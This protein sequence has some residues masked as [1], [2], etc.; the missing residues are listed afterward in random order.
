METESNNEVKKDN[1]VVLKDEKTKV[2]DEEVC[3][4][5]HCR[6]RRERLKLMEELKKKEEEQLAKECEMEN[7]KSEEQDG[8]GD[9]CGHKNKSYNAPSCCHTHKSASKEYE[10]RD[11]IKKLT[12]IL[13]SL[14]SIVLSYIDIWKLVGLPNLRFLDFGYVAVVLCGYEIFVTAIMG[15]KKKKITSS[16]LVSIAMIASIVLEYAVGHTGGHSHSYIFAAGE[17]A[18]FMALGGLIEDWTV[19]KSRKGIER[20]IAMTPKTAMVKVG[21]NYE[22]TPISKLMIGDVVLVKPNEQVPVD[23]EIVKGES[24]I[25]QSSV[26]G[27]FVPVDVKPGDKV[28]GATY[29][30]QGVIEVKVTVPPKDMTVN[31]LIELVKEAEGQKAPISR[32]ADRWASY[33]VPSAVVLSLLIGVVSYFAFHLT[34]AQ[35]LIRA[36]TILVVFC[37]CSLT[38]ATPTAV[39]AG[40]GSAAY[41][42]VII[43]S[44]DAIERLAKVDTVAFDKTGTIT[45]GELNVEKVIAFDKTKE[46]DLLTMLGSIEKYSE[47]PIGKAIYKYAT[48]KVKKVPDP[49]NTRSLVGV[50]ISAKVDGKLVK[51]VSYK[52]AKKLYPED[53]N[54]DMLSEYLD[55]GYSI[56]VVISNFK[57][58][59]AVCLFDTLRDDAKDIIDLLKSK[60]YSTIMLT[61]DNK[62]AASYTTSLVGVDKYVAELMPEDKLDA[63]LELKKEG[64]NVCMIGDGVND[65][66]ALAGADCS[67][68]MGALGSDVA[69]ETADVAIMN[70]D[71]RNVYNTLHLS[72]NTLGT[73]KRN[74]I[75][76]MSINVISV[77]LSLFGILTPTTGVLVHNFSSLFVVISSAFI[78]NTKYIKPEEEQKAKQETSKAKK[79]EVKQEDT[80]PNKSC[81]CKEK[82]GETEVKECCKNKVEKST[83]VMKAES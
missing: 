41:N 66:P 10:K 37:P 78:L 63:V 81:C 33:I 77:V 46:K 83:K 1:G 74:I 75:I 48:S 31:K 24:S 3:D 21:S 49:V 44:G 45:T 58:V 43:K 62:A 47:H 13:V 27:E 19:G 76:S 36:T 35:A 30:K 51:A 38:L 42:G 12:L 56:V 65:A 73:I 23:G 18:F 6:A 4:C 50:G 20:L 53:K 7:A 72:R 26:T 54:L 71:V 11:L 70:S 57:P 55:K 5:P 61:G 59:G 2:H 8:D 17:I 9:C 22:K 32:L 80:E 40:L 39:A 29:N 67:V 79:L 28:Y 82:T 60:N 15:L 16:L 64:H 34:I 25:D 69:V 68:A 14:V 52:E